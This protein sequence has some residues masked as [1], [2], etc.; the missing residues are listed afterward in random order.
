MREII[1]QP[2]LSYN[3]YYPFYTQNNNGGKYFHQV[4][5]IMHLSENLGI[6]IFFSFEKKK[7]R[8]IIINE[9]GD[10]NK[11]REAAINDKHIAYPDFAT[12]AKKA[13]NYVNNTMK[14]LRTEPGYIKTL[15]FSSYF[16]FNN[17]IE[18]EFD[19]KKIQITVRENNYHIENGKMVVQKDVY[20][21]SEEE[22][23]LKTISL[24]VGAIN[25]R[26]LY[27]EIEKKEFENRIEEQWEFYCKYLE[28]PKFIRKSEYKLK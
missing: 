22:G 8:E 13:Y 21:D 27:R 2:N 18:F 14:K 6:S 7:I 1:K 16:M 25:E 12:E 23:L 3:Y 10:S 15:I 4:I 11:L 9:I 5:T 24:T 28:A 19:Y 20:G 26:I 17:S